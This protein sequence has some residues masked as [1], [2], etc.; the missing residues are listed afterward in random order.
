MQFGGW[1]PTFWKNLL[2]DIPASFHYL[3]SLIPHLMPATHLLNLSPLHHQLTFKGL[4]GIISQNIVLFFCIHNGFS[5]SFITV[6]I[7]VCSYR[8]HNSGSVHEDFICKLIRSGKETVYWINDVEI[9]TENNVKF[10]GIPFKYAR[11]F[12]LLTLLICKATTCYLC[13]LLTSQQM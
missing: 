11:L 10:G 9:P 2:P 12:H 13:N 4:H 6:Y 7:Q 3:Y 8:R 1:L 5:Q